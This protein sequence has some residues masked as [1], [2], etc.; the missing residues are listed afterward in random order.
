MKKPLMKLT[1]AFSAAI[2]LSAFPAAT[3]TAT[4]AESKIVFDSSSY[5]EIE[6]SYENNKVTISWNKIAGAESYKVY[7]ESGSGKFT[8]L[9]S[10]KSLYWKDKRI[11]KNNLYRY[12]VYAVCGNEKTVPSE[13]LH[14]GIP[15]R[16]DAVI[17]TFDI[18]KDYDARHEFS[19]NS[20][21][22]YDK[23]SY[24]E[25][26]VNAAKKYPSA[27][28]GGEGGLMYD[29]GSDGYYSEEFTDDIADSD[30]DVSE[31][32]ETTVPAY[33][34]AFSDAYDE[35]HDDASGEAPAS[36][37]RTE[38]E[39]NSDIQYFYSG[40]DK[41]TAG[42]L[43]AGRHTDNKSY[44][45]FERLLNS[46][47]W[48]EYVSERDFSLDERYIVR[49]TD[50]KGKPVENVSAELRGSDGKVLFAAKT[51]NKGTAYIFTGFAGNAKA[52]SIAVLLPG[53]KES[54]YPLKTAKKVINV[55]YTGASSSEKQLDLMLTI[56]STGSM[57]DEMKY[58]EAELKDVIERVSKDN[59][60]IRIRVSVNF[61]RDEGDDYVYRSYN[62]REKTDTV[63]KSLAHERADGGGDYPEAVHRA[64]DIS[65]N[66]HD[67]DEN[68]TKLMFFVL[69]AP[70]HEG[71]KISEDFKNHVAEASA[72]GIR[73]I[74][75]VSSGSDTE[76]EYLMRSAA[77]ATGGTYI[78]LT[79]DSGVGNS[80][81]EPAIEQ[82]EVVKLND[83][84]VD[85]INEYLE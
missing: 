83:L 71:E 9:A 65:V 7:R 75:V 61:Y 82:Y 36:D 63:T 19:L 64:L 4:A 2:M 45:Q 29:S 24:G 42:T 59:G 26:T 33:S 62:F 11:A 13:I 68:S 1:A 70:P 53:G 30:Y 25:N 23:N 37:G 43:T 17:Y 20:F 67:W 72:E 14:V 39:K 52:E 76:T 21:D 51:N 85:V 47:E 57:S 60:S 27:A 10:T 41:I 22:T 58:L 32:A 54:V 3:Y 74:P 69:D 44:T 81:A 38:D 8:F 73:I 80:H 18:P 15:K 48:Q 55:K 56:D 79:D 50:E 6:G 46:E 34:E 16:G 40:N 84:M 66:E 77:A 35:A 31:E 12:K 78:F 49:V 28:S 5:C